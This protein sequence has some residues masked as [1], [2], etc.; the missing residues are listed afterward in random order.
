M[1]VINVKNDAIIAVSSS[2][3]T[4]PTTVSLESTGV[5]LGTVVSFSVFLGLLIKAISNFNEINS[6]IRELKEDLTNHTNNE[7]HEKILIQIRRI[8]EQLITHDKAFDV[9]VNNYQNRN[10]TLQF[11]I[12]QVAQT[13]THV[14]ESGKAELKEVKME[15]KE[16]EQELKELQK[17]LQKYETFTI[18][19]NER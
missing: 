8:Q 6:S 14:R 12:G 10:E 19:E 3:Q 9:H 2:Q 17:Y 5:F 13:V 15:V 11:T 18:R 1:E 7:G 4:S 16:L